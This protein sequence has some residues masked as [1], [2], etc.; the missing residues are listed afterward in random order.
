MQNSLFYAAARPY[1][2][3]G[4]AWRTPDAYG[5]LTSI[6]ADCTILSA[7]SYTGIGINISEDGYY[8]TRVSNR[9]RD[10]NDQVVYT[11]QLYK[12]TSQGHRLVDST[13]PEIHGVKLGL[14]VPFNLRLTVKDNRLT[15]YVNDIAM[16][17]YEDAGKQLSYGDCGMRVSEGDALFDNVRVYGTAMERPSDTADIQPTEY[18][19]D[20]EDE[21]AG[22]SPSHWQEY[23]TADRDADNWR[24]YPKDSLVYGTESV[25]GS[26]ATWLHV[27]DKNPTVKVKFQ[28]GRVGQ[29]ARVGFITRRSPDTAFVNIGYDFA[30]GKWYIAAQES[31]ASGAVYTW[32]DEAV[33]LS[34]GQ[35]HTA[36]I[37]EKGKSVTLRVDGKTAVSSDAVLRTGYG[38]VGAFTENA[39]LYLDEVQCTF[40]SG[41]VP[42]DGLTSYVAVSEDY[43]GY[44]EIESPDSGNTLIGLSERTKKLSRD[45]GLT[46]KDVTGE[47]TYK[48]LQTGVYP[49][50]L[51]MHNGQYLQIRWGSDVVAEVSEDLKSWKSAGRIVPTED[52][53]DADGRYRIM[54]HV[55]STTQVKRSNGD[56]RI[57]LAVVFRRYDATG[58]TILGH[59]T[60]VYYSDDYGQSW[61]CSETT[62]KELLPGYDDEGTTTWA[63]SKIIRCKDGTL[64]MYYSRNYLGCMQYT[65]SRDEGVTW[66]GLY[67]IPEMQCAMTSFSVFEDPTEEGTY[68]ML[69]LNGK[70]KFLGSVYPRNRISLVKSTDGQNWEFVMDCERMSDYISSQNGVELYQILDP[71]LYVTDQYVYIT[72]GRSEREFSKDD[73]FSHQQQRCYYIRAEKSKLTTRPWDAS[74]LASMRY[75]KTIAF[76]DAPQN[77]F[78]QGDLFNTVGTVRLTD[79]AGHETVEDISENCTVYTEPNMFRMGN[80][81]VKL[82][83]KNGTELFYD[84]TIVKNYTIQWN[85]SNGGTVE[86]ASARIMEG[87]SKTFTLVPEQGYKVGSVHID[88][89]RAPVH[90][91]SFVLENVTADVTVDVIFA[92]KTVWDY[93]VWIL[94][95]VV[96]CGGGVWL[97]LWWLKRRRLAKTAVEA[98]ET[99]ENLK[100]LERPKI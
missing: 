51:K 74:T 66:E 32:A 92:R 8:H 89:S 71:S 12:K 31:E 44:M 86:P 11:L 85:V 37:V 99:A 94:P 77:R 87:E 5:E 26:T 55:N 95:G 30:A 45:A 23:R 84:I 93:L 63:E 59:Y 69:W 22:Q 40:S 67:Q 16:L 76:Q 100:D 70:T 27:F 34:A 6:S 28:V 52:Q 81:T 79:F 20:F 83:Y 7:D 15:V 14:N 64:R 90:R 56:Y 21:T 65:V 36:E 80:Q 58:N 72:F 98:T 13:L 38:R 78:G 57:F 9:T 1:N 96:L 75:P 97:L 68:Y 43:A 91:R 4:T 42:A 17:T 88:G 29:N 53:V 54:L 73:A 10:D 19:D 49:S 46:W 25:S 33:S 48:Q 47:A 50:L 2:R 61:Q 60:Q 62:T 3:Y 82:Y 35:W 39:G 41:D 24:I 18:T